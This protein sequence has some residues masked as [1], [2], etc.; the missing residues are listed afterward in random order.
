MPSWACG[1]RVLGGPPE[2]RTDPES[3][4]PSTT[5]VFLGE[6][7]LQLGAKAID[8]HLPDVDGN[9][10]GLAEYEDKPILAVT[11]W[12]NHCPYVQGWEQRVTEG[13]GG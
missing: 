9:S 11:F 5:V 8:F 13:H 2:T 1:S 10:D 7:P 3:Q 4:S 12:C 6:M